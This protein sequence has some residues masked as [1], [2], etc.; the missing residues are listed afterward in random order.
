MA[1]VSR[2][3][4]GTRGNAGESR[5]EPYAA[6]PAPAATDL[7]GRYTG[8]PG[9]PGG[10]HPSARHQRRG[11]AIA[12]PGTRPGQAAAYPLGL[13][14]LMGDEITSSPPTPR[15]TLVRSPR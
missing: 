6:G 3:R 2:S 13:V 9:D 11:F 1:G 7:G 4:A 14:S 15:E 8:C 5:D 12:S 10:V